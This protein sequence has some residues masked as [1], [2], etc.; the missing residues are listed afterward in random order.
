MCGETG[1]A[2]GIQRCSRASCAAQ[3]AIT[4]PDR[5]W[6]QAQAVCGSPAQGRGDRRLVMVTA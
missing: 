6:Y 4:R 3:P 2:L 5:S 1:A